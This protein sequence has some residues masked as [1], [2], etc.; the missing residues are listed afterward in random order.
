MA[1]TTSVADGNLTTGDR[2]TLDRWTEYFVFLDVLRESGVT[3]MYGAS[4]YVQEEFSVN[5]DKAAKI[6]SAW[7]KT[8]DHDKSPSERAAAALNTSA[9]AAL[10]KSGASNV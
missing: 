7:M 10:S 3:N 2:R 4:P 8:F 6:L 1:T 5:R 9:R